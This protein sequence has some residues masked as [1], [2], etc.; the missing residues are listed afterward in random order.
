MSMRSWKAMVLIPVP[1]SYVSHK[2]GV[3]VSNAKDE[4][5]SQ[6]RHLHPSGD[7]KNPEKN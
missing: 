1:A 6:Y 5:W 7:L 4:A 2:L 3:V